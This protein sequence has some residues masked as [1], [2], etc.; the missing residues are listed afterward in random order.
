MASYL[1]TYR[2]TRSCIDVLSSISL[3]KRLDVVGT[4]KLSAHYWLV[5]V[6]RELEAQE[7]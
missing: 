5:V 4:G 2:S 6:V 1:I 7:S 3:L